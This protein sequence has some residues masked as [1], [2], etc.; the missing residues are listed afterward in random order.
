MNEADV[1]VPRTAP[2]V[3]PSEGSRYPLV[4]PQGVTFLY[5]GAA[6]SVGLRCWIHGLAGE[7]ALRPH[8]GD[9][10]LDPED[11][12]AAQLARR[13]QVR[14]GA[15][16]AR[17]N[18]SPTRSTRCTRPIRS[19]PTRSCRAMAT[20]GP[21]WTLPDR[22]ARAGQ[23]DELEVATAL[24]GGPAA[25]RVY[26]PARFRRSRRY[27]LLVVHDGTRL[28]ALRE[29]AGRARQPDPPARDPAADRGAHRLARAPARVRR[30]TS[31]T[32]GS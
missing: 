9:R 3:L 2:S 14:S 6:D 10:R 17:S 24:P 21:D 30:T 19:A 16:T 26:I 11:R 15:R 22:E 18:G 8:R 28:P 27:P 31:V 1:A 29:P 7:P 25:R 5:Q 32:R 23:I 13:V 20:C 12:P 4:D